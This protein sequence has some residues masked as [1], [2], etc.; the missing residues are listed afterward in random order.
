[1]VLN[2]LSKNFY[3][4]LVRRVSFHSSSLPQMIHGFGEK[5]CHQSRILL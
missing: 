4:I 2:V 5:T 1:M 3:A